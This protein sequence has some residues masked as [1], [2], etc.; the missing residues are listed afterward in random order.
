MYDPANGPILESSIENGD[1]VF[2]NGILNNEIEAIENANIVRA[3]KVAY[4]PSDGPV[5]DLVETFFQKLTFTSSFDRQLA[6]ALVGH[7]G[8]VL[9]GHS[10]GAIIA[11]NT[12]VN[13]GLRGQRGVVDKVWYRNTQIS[14]SRAYLSA[15]LAG[16]Q[17]NRVI[18]G[19]RT[20]DPSN[21]AG[22]NLNPF[23]FISGVVGLVDFPFGAEHHGLQ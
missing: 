9:S 22:P 18:Y 5:A 13:L 14:Q 8:I 19:S 2:V 7:K 16:V 17:G 11:A 10:Q 6:K 20:W 12:L 15:A 4:N 23:R 3:T 1:W 21:V